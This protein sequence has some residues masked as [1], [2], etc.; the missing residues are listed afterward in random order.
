M[1]AVDGIER[2]TQHVVLGVVQIF[3]I[4][5]AEVQDL[6][7]EGSSHVDAEIEVPP[8]DEVVERQVVLGN[9]VPQDATVIRLRLRDRDSVAQGIEHDPLAGITDVHG[10]VAVEVADRPANADSVGGSL[11]GLAGVSGLEARV[12]L[13]DLVG[14]A[15]EPVAVGGPVG[16]GLPAERGPAR[17]VVGEGRL[18][19]LVP[20]VAHIGQN[21]I[22]Q[23][24]RHRHVVVIQHVPRI[25]PIQIQR[26]GHAVVE[27]REIHPHVVLR[28]LF[29]AQV[30]V[31]VPD[32]H[33]PRH[34][35]A[36]HRIIEGSPVGQLVRVGRERQIRVA[37]RDAGDAVPGT[38]L[39]I[40][41]ERGD[42]AF[43]RQAPPERRAGE[44]TP[45]VVRAEPA[46]AFVA[47]A[48]HGE[49]A[50]V[51]VPVE[52]TEE[53]DRF[54]GRL[55]AS[56]SRLALRQPASRLQR[57]IAEEVAVQIVVVCVEAF[58]RPVQ[59]AVAAQQRHMVTPEGAR[60][61]PSG[62]Q[63][64]ALVGAGAAAGAVEPRGVGVVQAAPG[65]VDPLAA[66]SARQQRQGERLHR[67]EAHGAVEPE[68]PGFVI[69]PIGVQHLDR[70]GVEVSPPDLV[71]AGVVV[72]PVGGIPDG[73][74]TPHVVEVHAVEAPLPATHHVEV[75]GELPI[76]HRV[77]DV[78]AASDRPVIRLLKHPLIVLVGERGGVVG[79]SRRSAHDAHILI[80]ADGRPPHH[81]SAPV[82]GVAKV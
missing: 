11:N 1:L 16:T 31:G 69:A 47:Q 45:F 21:A 10:L 37:G 41:E 77:T 74:L 33:Q 35:L 7:S 63:H 78:D 9:P 43:V 29:P 19:A 55:A 49:E 24:G 15:Q 6:E 13:V 27:Q 50:V 57:V 79:R 3:V 8:A 38:Q 66:V 67:P 32:R 4:Q 39:E 59:V 60:V 48:Q 51:P 70:V 61:G 22:V 75:G 46:V 65:A 62:F 2:R 20:H 34:P 30:R 25:P 71:V 14:Q 26:A 82:R 80:V 56:E 17:H 40:A 58:V 44:H 5:A 12:R 18:D 68:V 52:T 76:V 54:V 64:L 81:H 36:A 72:D 53:P 28:L 23:V 73:R 42:E